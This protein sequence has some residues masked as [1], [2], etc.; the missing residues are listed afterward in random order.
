MVARKLRVGVI[1]GGKSGEHEVSLRSATSVMA[2]L[3]KSKYEVIPLGIAKSGQWLV[4]GDPMKLLTEAAEAEQADLAAGAAAGAP[5]R[6]LTTLAAPSGSLLPA[7]VNS[8]GSRLPRLDVV[9][10]VLHGPRGEDGTIQGL[11]EMAGLPYVGAGVLASAVGM[12]KIVQKDVF[13]QYGLPAVDDVAIKRRDWE[14]APLAAIEAVE[15]RLAYPVFVKPANLGSSVGISKAHD[16]NELRQALNFAAEYDRK[17]I[18]EA[19][20][21]S[22][23]E[24]ECSVLGND[25]PITSVCGEI[26]P[27]RDFYDYVAKYT[28]NS[29]ELIV[30]AVI[31]TDVQDRIREMARRAFLALDCAGMARV[32]FLVTR[33]LASIYLNELNTIPGFTNVSMFARLFE[34]TGLSY[35]DLLDRLVELALERHADSNRTKTSW[36]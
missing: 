16:R 1:F 6:S 22:P 27:K 33:D 32:D 8:A 13:R 31:P 17:L 34:A 15:R 36:A 28:D 4:G 10:P 7:I 12:D 29:T 11:L 24:I 18:V 9:F 19:A 23:R 25:D 3:D 21:P 20:V 35:G 5:A 14:S 30:P 2:A 26:V